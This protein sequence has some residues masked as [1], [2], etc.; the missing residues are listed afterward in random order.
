M[1]KSRRPN[2][3]I[4]AV[5]SIAIILAATSGYAFDITIDVAP[6]VLNLQSQSNVVTVHTDIAYGSVYVESVYLNGVPI[7]HWKADDQGNFVAKFLSDAIKTI[8]GLVIGGDNQ[9]KLVGE[10]VNGETFS[11]TQYIKVI[12]VMP[13][14]KN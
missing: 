13:K 14:G 1:N 4:F 2:A 11:G 8:D 5:F 3:F 9:L 7:D 10:T 6:N 12:D